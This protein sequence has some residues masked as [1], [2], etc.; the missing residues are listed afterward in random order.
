MNDENLEYFYSNFKQIR[1]EKNIAI[2]DVVKKTNIQE[3]YV[4]AIEN[5]NFGI[6]PTVYTKLFLTSY[7]KVIGLDSKEIVL[8]FEKHLSGKSKHS[9]FNKTPKF[10]E[11]KS[12]LH[13][14]KFTFDDNDSKNYFEC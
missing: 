8:S 7:S 1:K 12:E 2:K 10:I 13:K 3:E 14:N 5:G 11:N 6:L 4:T 9:T